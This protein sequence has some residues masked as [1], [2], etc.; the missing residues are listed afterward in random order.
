M[1]KLVRT[2]ILGVALAAMNLGSAAH[3][4]DAQAPSQQPGVTQKDPAA[5]QPT[6]PD[7]TT[8]EEPTTPEVPTGPE[9][10]GLIQ[11]PGTTETTRT[12]HPPVVRPK[13]LPVTVSPRTGSPGTTVTVRADL[14]GCQRPNS[15]RGFFQDAD[16]RDVDGLSIWLTSEHVSGGR[17][18]TGR[19]RIA[20]ND[21]AGLGQFGVVCDKSIVGF[22]N[23]RVQPSTSPVPVQVTPQ[24]AA[25]GTTVKI[26]AQVGWCQQ[27]HIWFYD[28]K[29][30][31]LTM[32]GGAKPIKPNL[33]IE[34][35][36]V[37]ASY[38]LT[39]KNAIGPARFTVV[40]GIDIDHARVGEASFQ[41][42]GPVSTPGPAYH[43]RGPVQVPTQI[44]TGLGGPADRGLDPML[45]LPAA[46]LLLI[47]LAVGLWLRQAARR[48]P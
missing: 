27:I 25:R 12:P 17:W 35:G 4:Q 26:T 13:V 37:T 45:L 9:D 48:R 18:Y 36:K 44:D 16:G 7:P 28:S 21:A 31:G 1:S 43:P 19:Y 23:F 22:A 5:G 33:P 30:D 3:A 14:R 8:P 34:D 41:V 2:F 39:R 32:A 11:D 42:R 46:G 20:N 15:G 47:V 38:T 24:A 29:S 40:C 6:A 10:P